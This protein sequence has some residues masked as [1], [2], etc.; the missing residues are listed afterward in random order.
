[1]PR[2]RFRKVGEGRIGEIGVWHIGYTEVRRPTL[3]QKLKHDAPIRGELWIEPQ[4]GWVVRTRLRV[5]DP[6]TGAEA[7]ILVEYA[8]VK[9]PDVWMPVKMTE[10]YGGGSS[11][12]KG[13]A[14]YSNF[15]RFET[16][17]RV[18]K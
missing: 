2:F 10:S 12:V 9:E 11:S 17:G 1:M 13:V 8:R 16:S 14:E 4:H 15:R 3:I 5:E 18:L 7:D 6:I